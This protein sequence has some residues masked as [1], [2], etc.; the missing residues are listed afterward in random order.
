MQTPKSTIPKEPTTD[1]GLIWTTKNQ[2]QICW[3][4]LFKLHLLM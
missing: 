4:W 2:N 3:R 1:V